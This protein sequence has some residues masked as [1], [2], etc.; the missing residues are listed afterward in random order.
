MGFLRDTPAGGWVY[1]APRKLLRKLLQ[2]EEP[3]EEGGGGLDLAAEEN[4]VCWKKMKMSSHSGGGG[5][6]RGALLPCLSTRI[7]TLYFHLHRA[8]QVYLFMVLFAIV[9]FGTP[10]FLKLRES[11]NTLKKEKP[12]HFFFLVVR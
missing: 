4:Q 3:E 6:P 7:L 2:D 1:G 11:S 12:P 9:L 10:P 5:G 8:L